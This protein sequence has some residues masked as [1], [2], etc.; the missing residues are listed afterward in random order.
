MEDP[1]NPRSS[2]LRT[3]FGQFTRG[4]RQGMLRFP[5]PRAPAA[6]RPWIGISSE[7]GEKNW[8][9]S[10]FRKS[11][12]GILAAALQRARGENPYTKRAIFRSSREAISLSSRPVAFLGNRTPGVSILQGERRSPPNFLQPYCIV[13]GLRHGPTAARRRQADRIEARRLRLP[14]GSAGSGSG[15]SCCPPQPRGGWVPRVRRPTGVGGCVG[16]S[17]NASTKK[18]PNPAKE[19]NPGSTIQP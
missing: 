7:T 19:H 18:V 8:E 10:E 16:A 5:A 15:A 11:G 1:Q 14:A 12:C 4:C 3:L 6:P 2:K 9:F 13:L 17:V